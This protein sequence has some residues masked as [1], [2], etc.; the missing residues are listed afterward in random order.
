[1]SF[2]NLH[3]VVNAFLFS[4][5]LL[6]VNSSSHFV[7]TDD[8]AFL[9]E[10]LD[11]KTLTADRTSQLLLP[12]S[13][14]RLCLTFKWFPNGGKSNNQRCNT[15]QVCCVLNTICQRGRERIGPHPA[16]LQLAWLR[17]VKTEH[18][19]CRCDKTLHPVVSFI[20]F[21]SSGFRSNI[22]TSSLLLQQQSSEVTKRKF[23]NFLASSV[24]DCPVCSLI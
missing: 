23:Y 24:K 11:Y 21:E 19:Y 5:W 1:M 18:L 22:L 16:F 9:L 13:Q 4:S 2:S 7:L 20:Y 17:L 10:P 14:N 15:C 12:A 8:Q 6:Q 3:Q